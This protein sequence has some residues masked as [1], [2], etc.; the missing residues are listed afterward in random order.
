[1]KPILKRWLA[2]LTLC[3]GVFYIANILSCLLDPW[4]DP[5]FYIFPQAATGGLQELFF[6]GV[7]F[8]I[9]F[10]MI[11]L[12]HGIS[13]LIVIIYL[14]IAQSSKKI[15]FLGFAR[16]AQ[17]SSIIKKR[18]WNQVLYGVLLCI[19]I[20]VLLFQTDA[21]FFWIRQDA[22][23][24]MFN[25]NGTMLMFP[26]IPWFW[27]PLAISVLILTTCFS[28]LDS[29]LVCIKKIPEHPQFSDTERVGN[30]FW[31]IIKGYAGISVIASFALLLF[32]PYGREASLITFPVY[33][34]L[35]VFF[36]MAT[37]ELTQNWGRKIIFT[38]VKRNRDP[39]IIELNY[40]KKAVDD[41][42]QLFL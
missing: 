35:N 26:M 32:T 2:S 24:R 27:F 38:I 16:I 14:R 15:V 3:V 6:L 10:F 19:N 21:F 36:Y 37:E 12:G 5:L 17:D 40:E 20:W 13:A 28:I 39:E 33:M 4:N 7:M 29:G 8:V 22:V 41:F 9:P 31:N 23:I 30:I 18:Y 1:M 11:P 25:D 42:N 34:A